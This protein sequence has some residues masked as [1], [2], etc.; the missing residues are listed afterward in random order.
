M[1]DQRTL[2]GATN[3]WSC[4][5][6]KVPVNS[7]A[8]ANLPLTIPSVNIF[9]LK[10]SMRRAYRQSITDGLCSSKNAV[11]C[12]WRREWEWLSYNCSQVRAKNWALGLA[13]R[14]LLMWDTS[15][16]PFSSFWAWSS[17][18]QSH[19]AVQSICLSNFSVEIIQVK[20]YS[21]HDVS[22]ISNVEWDFARPNCWSITDRSEWSVVQVRLGNFHPWYTSRWLVH[23]PLK[24]IS[25]FQA[26]SIAAWRITLRCEASSW[27]LTFSRS[28][29]HWRATSF[30]EGHIPQAGISSPQSWQH[31]DLRSNR[32]VSPLA[33]SASVHHKRRRLC[34]RPCCK[35]NV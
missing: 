29:T 3:L 27:W 23:K 4:Q 20:D 6:C 21:S 30:L 12:W 24:F 10:I 14:H 8:I 25:T 9:S 22:C 32:R 13:T 28:H 11:V 26:L 33:F 31:L 35:A 34:S 16:L 5:S 15:L 18:C 7:T 1:I 17:D 2:A 19:K